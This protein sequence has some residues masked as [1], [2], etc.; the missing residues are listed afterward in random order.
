MGIERVLA[1]MGNGGIVPPNRAIIKAKVRELRRI[2]MKY[3]AIGFALGV[4][5]TRA[6]QITHHT[7]AGRESRDNYIKRRAQRDIEEILRKL[8]AGEYID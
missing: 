7:D 5:E 6:W 2:G 4:S 3:S 1:A 8:D